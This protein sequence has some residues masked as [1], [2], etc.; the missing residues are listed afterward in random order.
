MVCGRYEI[1][2][3]DDVLRGLSNRHEVVWRLGNG[4]F[5]VPLDALESE[6]R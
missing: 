5:L 1:Q 6:G 4:V 2:Q 3:F